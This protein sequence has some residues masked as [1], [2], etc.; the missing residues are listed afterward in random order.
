MVKL[1]E[2]E[3]VVSCTTF[4]IVE[5]SFW[6]PV[7]AVDKF[8]KVRN[9]LLLIGG[10]RYS[11]QV[12]LD[13]GYPRSCLYF[14]FHWFFDH[15]ECQLTRESNCT[16]F[17]ISTESTNEHPILCIHAFSGIIIYFFFLILLIY[18]FYFY[19]YACVC[20][21]YIFLILLVVR[22]IGCTIRLTFCF[23]L[24]I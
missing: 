9:L 21:K 4:V 11:D 20:S 7:R 12:T 13:D 23:Y 8:D 19:L 14:K 15:V 5:E 2:K 17:L 18:I 24:F 16:A 3:S 6:G 22:P 1:D 10:N